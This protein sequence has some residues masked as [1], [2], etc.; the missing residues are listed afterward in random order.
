[1]ENRNNTNSKYGFDFSGENTQP[2][3]EEVNVTAE[4]DVPVH[5][6]DT[7]QVQP[8]IPGDEAPFIVLCGPPQSGKSMV[9]KSLASYLYQSGQNYT[10]SANPTLLNTSKYQSDC[11]HF[12]NVIGDP[13]TRMKNTVDYLMADI[14]DNLGNT[15]AHFLEAPGEDFFS[16]TQSA[17]EPNI[18]F[19]TYLD[20]IAQI[21][22]DKQ[23][24]VIYIILLDLDSSTSF[25]KDPSLRNKYQE[26]M[27]R[28][29]NRYVLHHPS[30]V[31]LLYNKADIPRN[32]AWANPGGITNLPAI[33]KDAKENYPR[34]FFTKKVLFMDVENYVFLP[35]CTGSYAQGD[36][37]YTAS[38]P[39]YPS[40]LWKEI[41]RLW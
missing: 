40:A 27:I 3:T 35:Y 17:R 11:D 7:T 36:D 26:K 13:D 9:L 4:Q 20:K 28:L 39:E 34:L 14:T 31:I 10:I 37:S 5:H 25:R 24:K 1:M 8:Q 41:T 12:N 6:T 32:G 16:L 21:S 15:V 30:K 23:R 38:G 2:Q 33:I 19:K 29:Y 18:G 22:P